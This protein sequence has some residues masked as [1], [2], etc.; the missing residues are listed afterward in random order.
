MGHDRLSENRVS[1]LNDFGCQ[2]PRI[3]CMQ[4]GGFELGL[5][6]VSLG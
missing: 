3:G 5:D 6:W 2:T 4:V 1:A